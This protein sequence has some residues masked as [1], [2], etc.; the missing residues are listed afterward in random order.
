M[1]WASR[2]DFADS[3]ESGLKKKK[4]DIQTSVAPPA[5]GLRV[6]VR[7][8]LHDGQVLA[9]MAMLDSEQSGG[10]TLA[11]EVGFAAK[12]KLKRAAKR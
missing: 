11:V 7:F 9:L 8:E 1:S 12:T 10:F 3:W 2:D 5:E 6:P 4:L